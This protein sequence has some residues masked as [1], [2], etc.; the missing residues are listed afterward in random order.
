MNNKLLAIITALVAVLVAIATFPVGF[1]ALLVCLV[2]SVLAVTIIQR[3]AT[4]KD[5]LIRVFLIGLLVRI[6]FATFL[7]VF[8]YRTFFGE[9]SG[10]YDVFG[11]K[12][13]NYWWGTYGTKDVY[14]QRALSIG[15]AGWGMKYLIG[16]IYFLVGRNPFAAQLFITVFGAFTSILIYICSKKIFN[17]QRVA[18]IAALI[19]ALCPSLIIWSSNIL[20]DGLIIFL[21]ALVMVNILYLMERLRYEQLIL[22]ALAMFGILSLRFYIFYMVAV[23]VVGSFLVG[24]SN[25]VKSI[26]GRTSAIVMLGVAFTYFG[27]VDTATTD[28]EKYG[29]LERVQISRDYLAGS[30]NSGYASDTD[31]STTGA[32]ISALPLGLTY[33][34]LAPF[35]WEMTSFRQAITLPEMLVWWASIP[36]LIIGLWYTIKHRLRSAIA[37][38]LFTLMLTIGYSLFQGNVGTAYRQRAQIQVFLFIF[39]S[40]GWTFLKERK[41]NKRIAKITYQKRLNQRIQSRV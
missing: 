22:L 28:F 34:M 40:V 17:N 5:F 10:V 36:L 30:A 16:A 18:K 12:I 24:T 35:P 1:S 41:E 6:S 29:S 2:P 8:E 11:D 37:I 21:L 38:L 39:I 26:I 20:K 19:V 7:H 33:L 32:A 25:S 14:L 23:S 13:A 15:D 31:V 4:E 27:A 3:Y 9:D